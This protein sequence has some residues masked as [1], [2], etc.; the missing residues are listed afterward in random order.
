MDAVNFIPI[1]NDTPFT[2]SKTSDSLLSRISQLVKE[3]MSK[4]HLFLNKESEEIKD[5]RKMY[6]LPM[7]VDI[8]HLQS[9]VANT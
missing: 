2:S 8:V 1:S 4:I 6:D 9:I 3:L 5:F 7:S